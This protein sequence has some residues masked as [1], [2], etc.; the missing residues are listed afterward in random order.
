MARQL[1]LWVEVVVQPEGK[2]DKEEEREAEGGGQAAAT[3][4]IV[5]S[6]AAVVEKDGKDKQPGG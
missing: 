6:T 1:I 5:A 2:H 4:E 3:P